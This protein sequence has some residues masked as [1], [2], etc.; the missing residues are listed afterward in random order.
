MASK[1]STHVEIRFIFVALAKTLQAAYHSLRGETRLYLNGR[2]C[3]HLVFA[4]DPPSMSGRAPS[5]YRR[6]NWHL[7]CDPKM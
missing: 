1:A 5:I 4:F 2:L 6:G 3:L 7:A